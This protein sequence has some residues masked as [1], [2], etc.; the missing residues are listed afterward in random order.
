MGA[1]SSKKNIVADT[2]VED[3]SESYNLINIHTPTANIGITVFC[4]LVGVVCLFRLYTYMVRARCARPKTGARGRRLP[5]RRD[6]ATV[7]MDSHIGHAMPAQ[8]VAVLGGD[9]RNSYWT[10]KEDPCMTCLEEAWTDHGHRRARGR[11]GHADLVG[12][13]NPKSVYGGPGLEDSPPTPR[14]RARWPGGREESS[15][16]RKRTRARSVESF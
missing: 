10:P 2:M 5:V 12:A 9:T 1:K 16:P 6:T 7:D 14:L 11:F 15:P 3:D 13:G 4:C 8:G